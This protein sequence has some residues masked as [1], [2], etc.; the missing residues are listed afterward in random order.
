MD[1]NLSTLWELVMD[2]E[3][4][5]AAVHEVTESDTNERMNWTDAVLEKQILIINS[6]GKSWHLTLMFLGLRVKNWFPKG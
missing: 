1:M 5:N 3:T 4:W 2:R 6:L